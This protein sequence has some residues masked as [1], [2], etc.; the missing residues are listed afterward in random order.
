MTSSMLLTGGLHRCSGGEVK[1]R[2][3]CS[4]HA[5]PV[6]VCGYM[7]A[8]KPGVLELPSRPRSVGPSLHAESVAPALI[9]YAHAV[10]R[11]ATAATSWPVERLAKIVFAVHRLHL[12][13]EELDCS[14]R[15]LD[16]SALQRMAA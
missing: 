6:C 8:Q 1:H 11:F 2:G 13:R 10:P 7:R 4:R 3:T 5:S 12:D 14:I 16:A 9:H 15:I